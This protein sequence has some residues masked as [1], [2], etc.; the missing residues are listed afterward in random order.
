[1][2]IKSVHIQ[3]MHNVE[4]KTY[5]LSNAAYFYGENGAGKSTVLQA[6]QLALLGYIP[7][8]NKTKEGIFRHANC[9]KMVVE[10][11]LDDDTTIMRSW[12]R[13]GRD[14]VTE[15]S[16]DDT[17]DL[18]G[19]IELP[20]LNFS[21][22]AGMTANKL[23][24]WFINFLPDADTAIDWYERL[25]N[26]VAGTELTTES[27]S[28]LDEIEAYANTLSGASIQMV[29]D[30]NA[31]LKEQAS[32]KKGELSRIQSTIQSLVM[33]AD[34][35]NSISIEDLKQRNLDL[36]KQRDAL[37]RSV[38]EIKSKDNLIT[39]L[40]SLDSKI[41][42]I[43][44]GKSKED[45]NSEIA[46]MTNKIKDYD[47]QIT[48]LSMN[49]INLVEKQNSMNEFVSGNGTCPY[50]K[51]ICD[52]IQQQVDSY[53]LQLADITDQMDNLSNAIQK[54]RAER[55]SVA[56]NY[57]KL[58]TKLT[59]VEKLSDTRDMLVTQIGD[60]HTSEAAVG[61]LSTIESTIDEL[62]NQMRYNSDL[63]AKL[64]ANRLYDST[65][66][67]IT[68]EKYQTE[69]EIDILKKLVKLT[70]VNGMQSELATVPFTSFAE[71]I[72]KHL[73]G[74]YHDTDTSAAFY[75]TEK[76]NSFSFGVIRSGTYVQ[77]DLLSSGEKCL[78]TFAMLMGIVEQS[79]AKLHML[80]ID[81][82]LDHLDDSKVA[83]VFDYIYSQDAVQIILAGVKPCISKHHDNIVITVIPEGL[84]KCLN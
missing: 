19:S 14:I 62:N 17:S 36:Q 5:Q 44:D 40:K 71:G 12:Q 24:D 41:D 70:D 25:H 43:L 22:F 64:T 11:T 31:H 7:G 57:K 72:T 38:T 10:L 3:G 13:K 56:M 9:S 79:N 16:V 1:M 83:N 66:D 55:H 69:Q 35:D 52:A 51:T 63:I 78:F 61:A 53:K 49:H 26:A 30:L 65:I 80:M 21:E 37:M 82:M 2:R 33:Y 48:Q 46:D 77:Y 4:D 50:T 32:F 42:Q 60:I 45:I 54:I 74:L 76:A 84:N 20:I 18:L 73:Q 34:C 28:Y 15:S 29:R 47:T 27:N 67:K 58:N 75:I 81:D 8:Y 39:E 6:I 59:D 68:A 23:K